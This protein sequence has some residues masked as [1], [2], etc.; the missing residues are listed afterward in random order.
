[1]PGTRL[2]W[3]RTSALGLRDH[4]HD[5]GHDGTA[6]RHMGVGGNTPTLRSHPKSVA[7]L[8]ALLGALS[9][10]VRPAAALGLWNVDALPPGGRL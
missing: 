1:M 3:V 7:A 10:A 4:D 5:H 9:G 8:A 2:G 6:D